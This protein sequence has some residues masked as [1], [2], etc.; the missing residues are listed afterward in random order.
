MDGRH[1]RRNLAL[2]TAALLFAVPSVASCGFNYATDREY[3]PAVG[4]NNQDGVVDVLNAVIVAKE[5]GSGTF[6]AS[7]SNADPTATISVT[8]LDFG[9]NSTI[10]VAPFDPIE[11]GPR[12]LVNLADGQGIKV[13]GDITKGDF[14]AV[15][16]VFDNGETASL[17]APVVD[18]VYQW[19]GMDNATGTP[20][21]PSP[22]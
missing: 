12:Q 19:E 4:A 5:D 7:L 15:T 18:A 21:S 16:L 2:T 14:I 17:K 1:L 20:A 11:V 10:E 9:S 8:S 22:S 6:L 13:Q 3:T